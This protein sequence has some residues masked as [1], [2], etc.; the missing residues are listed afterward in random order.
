MNRLAKIASAALVVAMPGTATAEVVYS[1]EEDPAFPS[2]V[3]IEYDPSTL[4]EI[5]IAPDTGSGLPIIRGGAVDG[6][7]TSPVGGSSASGSSGSTS[8]SA[9]STSSLPAEER[10]ASRIESLTPQDVEDIVIQREIE[11]RVLEQ[12]VR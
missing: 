7:L 4:P 8:S 1:I 5:Q 6:S 12:M 3:F 10:A 2:V 11:D 9:D